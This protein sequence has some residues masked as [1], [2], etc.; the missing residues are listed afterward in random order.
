[1]TGHVEEGAAA[2]FGGLAGFSAPE[3]PYRYRARLVA[4]VGVG[5]VA[6]VFLGTLAASQGWVAALT[7]GGTA[8]L[9]S[10]VCQA[11]ELLPPRE[12]MLLMTV[13]AAT[14]QPATAE[15]ALERAILT[16]G[17]AVPVRTQ[18]SL[19]LTPGR[20]LLTRSRSQLRQR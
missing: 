14:D 4:G 10:F 11:A 16:A 19:E 13:L 8:G 6:S 17:G 3:S 12:L 2:A 7:A 1:V 15:T 18:R 9:A 5:L 20:G